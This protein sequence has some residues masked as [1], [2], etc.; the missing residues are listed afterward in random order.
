[1]QK[2]NVRG[3]MRVGL[4]AIKDIPAGSELCFDYQMEMFDK[5]P[6]K[7]SHVEHLRTANFEA[8]QFF[9]CFFNWLLG[10]R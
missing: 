4:F 5:K 7:A 8:L 2:W 10:K 6:V 1:M 9:V 3:V